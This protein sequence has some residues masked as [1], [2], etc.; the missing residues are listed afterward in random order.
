M[1][2]TRPDSSLFSENRRAD[3]TRTIRNI[4]ESNS[5]KTMATSNFRELVVRTRVE[6]QAAPLS[7]LSA[8][9]IR[10]SLRRSRQV[11]FP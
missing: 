4:I 2:D 10:R 11:H 7:E 1:P 9:L 3:A 6:G 5:L 8:L